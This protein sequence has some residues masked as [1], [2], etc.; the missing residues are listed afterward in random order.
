[1]GV[2]AGE[3]TKGERASRYFTAPPNVEL[4]LGMKKQLVQI[5]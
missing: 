1:M 3:A 2:V 5:M 4:V